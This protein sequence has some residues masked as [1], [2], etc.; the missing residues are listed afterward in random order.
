MYYKLKTSFLEETLNDVL[1]EDGFD[2]LEMTQSEDLGVTLMDQ[3]PETESVNGGPQ[4]PMDITALMQQ[5]KEN[6]FSNIK[7]LPTPQALTNLTNR[8][9][10]HVI[11][12]FEAVEE[13]AQNASAWGENVSK[14]QPVAA[15][16]TSP[17]KSV[18]PRMPCVKPSVS[19]KLFQSTRSFAKRNPRKPLART[20]VN[21]SATG[22]LTGAAGEQ[23][24][25]L[26]DLET[27]LIRKAQKHKAEMITANALLLTDPKGSTKEPIKTQVDEGWLQR[28]TVENSLEQPRKLPVKEPNNNA[29][30]TRKPNYGL[31]NLDLSKL[32]ASD[33]P[34]P[35]TLEESKTEDAVKRVQGSPIAPAPAPIQ[36]PIEVLVQVPVEAAVEE[37]LDSNSD[38]IVADSEEETEQ[39]EYRHIA[40]RRRIMPTSESPGTVPEMN[41]HPNDP[42]TNDECNEEK[43]FSADEDGDA[44]YEP[45]PKAKR[46]QATAKRQ[47][48]KA[49]KKPKVEK[50][51]KPKGTKAVKQKAEKT[52][53]TKAKS[54]SKAKTAAAATADQAEEELQEQPLNP[55]D[56][57]YVLA[58]ESGDITCVPRIKLD[59]LEKA[60]ETAQRYISNFS[61]G[62]PAGES[63]AAA[64]SS[65]SASLNEK[66][67]A[68]RL[69]LE[70]RIAAGKLNENFVTIN[71]QK[72]KFSRGK[73][74]VNF[75]KYKKQQWKHKKR[76]AALAGPDMDMG[77]CDGGVLTCFNCGQVGHFA[78]Q[79]KIKGDTL[80]PLSAQLEE[81]PSPFPTL[82]EVEM[83]ATQGALA[84][85]SR[86]IER[87]PQ[88]AN[89]NVIY[90]HTDSSSSSSDEEEKADPGENPSAELN[91]S[92]DEG[93]IDFEA[94]DAAVDA[95][96]AQKVESPIKSYVGHKIPEQFLK[97]AGL[98]ASSSSGGG[99]ARTQHGGVQPLYELKADGS[100]Q[101]P[102]AEVIEAL[103]MFGHSSFRKGKLYALIRV[104]DI[105]MPCCR[106]G[107]C[108]D[109]HTQRH[110][111]VGHPQH[112]Q[113]QVP[114]LSAARLPVQS[115][116]GSH[117][118]GHLS[119]GVPH[120]GPG[121][122]R[123]AL[124]A[125]PLPAHESNAT[126]AAQ[127]SA[128]HSRW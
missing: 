30:P 71:I 26:L 126:A 114:V 76:V 124:S 45:E 55:K 59:E 57:K 10:N 32:R 9:E 13:L 83:M 21:V 94:L 60:D 72:K 31:S 49:E 110:V 80:L 4:L 77:G 20:A 52:D 1:C 122:G 112:G 46:K 33:S 101:D 128:A 37:D 39:T 61:S 123:A 109:A 90:Q 66:R 79:C 96:Q 54:K 70:A 42:V 19:N 103:H 104:I 22:S 67:A 8:D 18:K 48:P 118:I 91:M 14:Q 93:D 15:V 41:P 78:Q 58:L 75:S 115:P 99:A 5:S 12:K 56:L 35:T 120:G 121:D 88:A 102:T 6:A 100:V 69:K 51:A 29:T 98:D 97:E 111:Y 117:Y 68:A 17:T 119:A 92:S 74:T 108:C 81:D 3:S 87:L 95:A 85:H 84:A 24:E 47:K 107:S 25:E 82:A 44:N 2:V 73:K 27:I 53:K 116:S 105:W 86:N 36:A 40:K 28:N 38:S 127:D 113:R 63:G 7:E 43:D 11:R 50:A 89:T 106:S 23:E 62:L 125:R 64:S 16:V 65:A 34:L